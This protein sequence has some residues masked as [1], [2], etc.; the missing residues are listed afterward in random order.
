MVRTFPSS[1]G[2]AILAAAWMVLRGPSLNRESV[3]GKARSK[4]TFTA[5]STWPTLQKQLMFV[6]HGDVNKQSKGTKGIQIY[7]AL[8]PKRSSCI[9][10]MGLSNSVRYLAI[11]FPA[12]PHKLAHPTS[13]LREEECG[14][15]TWQ[16]WTRWTHWQ[17]GGPWSRVQPQAFCQQRVTRAGSRARKKSG[18][19]RTAAP[20]PG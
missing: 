18:A 14:V 1:E 6:L 17:S 13:I 8:K 15:Q 5:D 11:L 7:R 19:S 3:I 10:S 9:F 12:T 2:L 16:S 4:F 20:P